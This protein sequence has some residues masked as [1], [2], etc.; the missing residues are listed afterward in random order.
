MFKK[1]LLGVGVAV[2][3]LAC[4]NHG[5]NVYGLE[6]DTVEITQVA[7]VSKGAIS[8]SHPSKIAS[9]VTQP[10]LDEIEQAKY[11]AEMRDR[12][13]CKIEDNKEL[14]RQIEAELEEELRKEAERKA[15][16]EEAKHWKQDSFRITAYCNCSECCGKW[17]DGKTA[18]M[19]TACEG[20]TVAVDPNVIP[21][22]SKVVIDGHTYIAE[23]TGSAIKGNRI[24]LYISDHSRASDYGVKYKTVDYR[25]D[26]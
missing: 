25:I 2:V 3:G 23:D 24:D 20:R 7:V 1:K 6:N 10:I 12:V 13:A 19:T 9:F 22:G 16:E 4:L 18:S 14:D 15:A 8:E 5:F 11:E 17:A 21:L 26:W